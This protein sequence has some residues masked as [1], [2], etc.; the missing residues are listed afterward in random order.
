MK[1]Y[2]K[3]LLKEGL[4]ESGNKIW[5]HGSKG[6]IIGSPKVTVTEFSTTGGFFVSENE[7]FAKR[8][9]DGVHVSKWKVK[10]GSRIFNVI[11]VVDFYEYAEE[12]MKFGTKDSYNSKAIPN[13][14]IDDYAKLLNI[15]NSNG[16]DT[17]QIMRKAYPEINEKEEGAS[18]YNI[19]M[20]DLGS[21]YGKIQHIIRNTRLYNYNWSDIEKNSDSIKNAGFDG[22]YIKER[23]N[24]NFL[25]LMVFNVDI[26]ERV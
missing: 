19:I 17:Q 5:Y 15:N 18:I 26:L 12:I 2:I 6:E 11:D 10:D 22:V 21:K 3:R 25:N 16:V 1:S 8:W 24:H 4:Y 20:D 23:P 9:G 13:L 7:D 14:D